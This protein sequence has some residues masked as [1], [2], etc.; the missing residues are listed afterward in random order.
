MVCD[1]SLVSLLTSTLGCK[2]CRWGRIKVG[3]ADKKVSAQ[4]LVYLFKIGV[5]SRFSLR[6][7]SELPYHLIR[8]EMVEDLL[9]RC[10]STTAG[11]MPSCPPVLW[12]VVSDFQEAYEN[13]EDPEGRREVLMIQ[14]TLKIG[15]SFVPR[16]L[17][18]W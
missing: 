8:A 2:Y 10:C 5:L 15:V 1:G 18:C 6:T 14:D 11:Y 4:P 12:S 13:L 9:M 17:T 3:E 16:Y 7:F